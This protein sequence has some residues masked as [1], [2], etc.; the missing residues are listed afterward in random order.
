M[1][2][3]IVT[4]PLLVKFV[5]MGASKVLPVNVMVIQ[6]TNVRLSSTTARSSIRSQAAHGTGLRVRTVSEKS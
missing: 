5:G 1:R 6:V 3:G 2:F 4:C